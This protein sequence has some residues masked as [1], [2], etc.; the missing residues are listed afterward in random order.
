MSSLITLV[1]SSPINCF[2][3][4]GGGLSAKKAENSSW[5]QFPEVTRNLAKCSSSSG[6]APS[7][8]G[9]QLCSSK[10]ELIP[11]NKKISRFTIVLTV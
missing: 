3:V 9:A 8:R 11:T 2:D 7:A 5:F 10:Y 1:G 6:A 4:G